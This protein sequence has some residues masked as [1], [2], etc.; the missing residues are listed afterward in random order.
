MLMDWNPKKAH[1]EKIAQNEFL[2]MI[3]IPHD[4]RGR[5]PYA[6]YT[7]IK[8]RTVPLFDGIWA[9][10][11]KLAHLQGFQIAKAVLSVEETWTRPGRDLCIG[12]LIEKF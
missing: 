7:R 3:S 11:S 5:C 9:W 1:H 2:A 8:F 4:A 10:A 6:V 12:P